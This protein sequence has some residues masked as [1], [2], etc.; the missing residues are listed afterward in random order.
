MRK[1]LLL[2]L[3]VAPVHCFAQTDSLKYKPKEEF[4]EAEVQAYTFGYELKMSSKDEDFDKVP[5]I[6]DANNKARRFRSMV[7]VLN[8]MAHNGWVMMSTYA[9]VYRGNSGL[10]HLI[11]KRSL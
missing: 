7:G 1:L 6:K 9:D 11:F 5:Y 3:F 8:Y 4:C 2:L 10:L